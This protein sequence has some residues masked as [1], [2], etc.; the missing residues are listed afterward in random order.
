[1]KNYALDI[2]NRCIEELNNTSDEEFLKRKKALGLT[3]K[4]YNLETYINDEVEI[5]MDIEVEHEIKHKITEEQIKLKIEIDNDID[6][7]NNNFYHDE[8]KESPS[9]NIL[10]A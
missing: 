9:T 4:T 7:W 10:A 8:Y 1:M 2:L 3:D 6:T 5:I